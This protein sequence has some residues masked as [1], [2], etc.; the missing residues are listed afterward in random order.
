MLISKEPP[1]GITIA[2][3]KIAITNAA[4]VVHDA[5][6]ENIHC[7]IANCLN[8]SSCTNFIA[9]HN[10][11]INIYV[12]T[13]AAIKSQAAYKPYRG[14]QKMNTHNGNAFVS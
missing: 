11:E 14:F 13:I 3:L 8:D 10:G 4:T 9:L 12:L 7:L 1:S 5:I 6:R 2:P